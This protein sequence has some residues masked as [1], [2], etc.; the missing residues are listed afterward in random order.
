MIR[1]QSA[2]RAGAAFRD[3]GHATHEE[4]VERLG[5]EEMARIASELEHYGAELRKAVEAFSA[6]AVQE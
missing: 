5:V 1:C 4:L 3:A 2:L 6:S